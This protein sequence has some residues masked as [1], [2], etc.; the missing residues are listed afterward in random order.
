M[1]DVYVVVFEYVFLD[2][3]CLV[4][5]TLKRILSAK[6]VLICEAA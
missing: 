2:V 5:P 6:K 4:R 3:S 1:C